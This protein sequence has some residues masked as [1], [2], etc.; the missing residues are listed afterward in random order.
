[1]NTSPIQ[2]LMAL[3]SRALLGLC[4]AAFAISGTSA[5]AQH[6]GGGH[7]GGGHG[8]GF[9][10]GHFGGGGYRGGYWGGGYRGGYYRNYYPGYA[11]GGYGY[12]PG[13]Y[14][15]GGYGYGGYYPGLFGL[16]G[17]GYGLGY[18]SGYGY[19]GYGYGYGGYGYGYN[20]PSYSYGSAHSYPVYG[21]GTTYPGAV[22]TVPG[23]TY[24]YSS[25]YGNV[26]L[27][28]SS[29]STLSAFPLPSL[30][31]DEETVSDSTGQG[32]RIVRDYPDSL[33]QRAGLQP[34]DVIHSANG[35]LTQ[36]PGNLAWIINHQS[37]NGV[38]NLN[39]R[40]AGSAQDTTV[41]VR[42]R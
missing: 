16:A 9:R 30:G 12:Y 42:L 8:G 33:A 5:L 14:G 3:F 4:V 28:S 37:P 24:T 31:I 1:M 26:P 7:G 25:A 2:R 29:P 15:L 18:G 41:T 34:G 40:K 27:Q 38:L 35:Y 13:F 36:S 11:Y 10:G 23:S 21:E 32:I 20:Y 22:T 6:H 39:V 17:L 19:P